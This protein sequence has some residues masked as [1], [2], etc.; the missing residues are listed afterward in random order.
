MKTKILLLFLSFALIVSG[1]VAS[2]LSTR[3]SEYAGS[4]TCQAC[5]REIHEA[6]KTSKH[7]VPFAAGPEGAAACKTCHAT[8]IDRETLAAM[9][10]NVGCE[11]CHGP[12]KEHIAGNGD[13]KKL[14]SGRSAEICGRC[15]RGNLFGDGAA[16]LTDYGR[17]G[18]KPAEVEGLPLIPVSPEKLPPHLPGVHPSLVYNMWLASGHAK[19]PERS[20]M[21]NGRQWTGPVTCVACHNPHNSDNL[22]QLVMKREEICAQCHFQADV[23]QGRGARGVAATRSL[24]T[25]TPCYTCH[26]TEGNHLMKVLRPDDPS[27]EADRTDSCTACHTVGS[28]E[29]RT[30]QIRDWEQ[31]FTDTLEPIQADLD[32]VDKMIGDKRALDAGVK[33]KLD[34]VKSNLSIIINDGSRGVHNLDYALEVMAHA[35]KQL[36]AIKEAAGAGNRDGNNPHN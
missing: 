5:H 31:W 9:E 25:P 19:T 28:R 36:K 27:L 34:D 20:L 13:P 33:E 6:W 30:N 10:N 18:M 4:E 17:P 8:G 22:A 23:L 3:P 7:A 14:I 29:M 2:A 32:A 16:R 35:K 11:S 26:M 24:H 15:H 1:V 21:I 12:G